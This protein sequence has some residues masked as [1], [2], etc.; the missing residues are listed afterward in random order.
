MQDRAYENLSHETARI[1]AVV[2]N[3]PEFL[4]NEEKYKNQERG[5]YNMC[6]AMN[7][8]LIPENIRPR[9]KQLLSG[10]DNA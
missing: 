7:A 5:G 1:I 2:A 8:L 3:V 4:E 10:A 6:Q 9:M